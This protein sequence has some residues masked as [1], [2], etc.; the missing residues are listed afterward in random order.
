LNCHQTGQGRRPRPSSAPVS[1]RQRRAPPPFGS[2]QVQAGLGLPGGDRYEPLK[3]GENLSQNARWSNPSLMCGAPWA[4]AA[5][6]GEGARFCPR[7][8]NTVSQKTV[9]QQIQRA[10]EKPTERPPPVPAAACCACGHNRPQHH[11][12]KRDATK[13]EEKARW[14]CYSGDSRNMATILG[15]SN[16][17]ETS[18]RR[19][20]GRAQASMA[21]AFELEALMRE[22]LRPSSSRSRRG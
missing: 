16:L 19:S 4:G 2:T 8:H 12:F 21:T 5:S 18:A 7:P 15:N 22:R 6:C 9:E 20:G 14:L 13:P 17:W 1:R 10:A 3:D 11:V